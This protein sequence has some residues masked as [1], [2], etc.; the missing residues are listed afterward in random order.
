M[1]HSRLNRALTRATTHNPFDNSKCPTRTW[2]DLVGQAD[3]RLFSSHIRADLLPRDLLKG[4]GKLIYVL[5][6]PKDELTSMHFFQ[7]EPRVGILIPPI[8]NLTLHSLISRCAHH[9]PAIALRTCV[10]LHDAHAAALPSLFAL[11]ELHRLAP[12]PSGRLARQR[13]RARFIEAGSCR[14]SSQLVWELLGPHTGHGTGSL[15]DGPKQIPRCVSDS[16]FT[17]QPRLEQ[18]LSNHPRPPF[19]RR[20]TLL[21]E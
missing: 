4:T 21:C 20:W 13:T 2:S 3:P 18:T 17:S 16:L 9:S 7:G 11:N 15:Y 6:N 1:V 8:P 5:R 10:Q 19:A 12:S 14:A